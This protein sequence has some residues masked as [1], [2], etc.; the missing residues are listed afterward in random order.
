MFIRAGRVQAQTHNM[1]QLAFFS[2]GGIETNIQN[3]VYEAGRDGLP[4]G[5]K[6]ILWVAASAY[7]AYWRWRNL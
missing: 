6:W 1:M 2:P 4:W 7:F 3:W 5:T